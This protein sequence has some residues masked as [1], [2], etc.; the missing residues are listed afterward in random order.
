ME[1]QQL[2]KY[3]HVCWTHRKMTSS[4][5][6]LVIDN[7]HNIHE[8]YGNSEHLILLRDKITHFLHRNCNILHSE[9]W[10]GV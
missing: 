8:G 3:V 1:L 9:N 5:S 7:I 4:L 6:N 2:L 10:E